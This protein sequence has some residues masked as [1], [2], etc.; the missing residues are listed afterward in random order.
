MCRKKCLIRVFG[1]KFSSLKK[2]DAWKEILPFFV[3]GFAHAHPW[4]LELLQQTGY[5]EGNVAEHSRDGK[6]KTW[7][8]PGSLRLLNR[9]FKSGA[10][11]V[12]GLIV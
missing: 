1:E 5:H 9:S 6:A 3:S 4:C 8:S 2:R 12:I 11:Y 10:S 7:K